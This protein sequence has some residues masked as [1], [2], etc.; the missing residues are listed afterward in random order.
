LDRGVT[1]AATTNSGL[2]TR[3]DIAETSFQ[4]I[5]QPLMVQVPAYQHQPVFHR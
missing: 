3:L 4:L 1:L 5:A 2:G